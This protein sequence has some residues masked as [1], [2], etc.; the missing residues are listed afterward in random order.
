LKNAT[1]DKIF[2]DFIDTSYEFLNYQIIKIGEKD[3]KHLQQK[4]NI[5][6]FINTI[7]IMENLSKIFKTEGYK[8]EKDID[9]YNYGIHLIDN[10]TKEYLIYIGIVYDNWIET[11][12]PFYLGYTREYK[13]K[14]TEKVEKENIN[15]LIKYNTD[16]YYYLIISIKDLLGKN[17]GTNYIKEKVDYYLN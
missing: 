8:V 9:K 1:D 6:S 2:N 7:G 12:E 13:K 16:D 3:M 14:V 11:G 17:D 5:E 15:N 4:N 10:N